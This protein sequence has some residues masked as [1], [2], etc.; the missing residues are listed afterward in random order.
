MRA[1]RLGIASAL[2]ALNR[3]TWTAVDQ[4]RWNGLLSVVIGL[5]QNAVQCSATESTSDIGQD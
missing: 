1:R 2:K 4:Y 3:A 5:C